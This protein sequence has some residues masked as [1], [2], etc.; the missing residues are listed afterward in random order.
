MLFDR[1]EGSTA[2]IVFYFAG[3]FHCRFPIHTKP[4]Q[5]I[6]EQSVPFIDPF[7][8]FAARI[9]QGKKPVF[10]GDNI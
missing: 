1:G 7:G 3:I 9:C 4:D 8:H 2:D 10:I 6:G 5:K